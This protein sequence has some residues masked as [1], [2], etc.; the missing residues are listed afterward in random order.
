M[1]HHSRPPP[2]TSEAPET[3]LA[4]AVANEPVIFA[5][6][7]TLQA[8]SRSLCA[9]P[10]RKRLLQDLSPATS[11]TSR[12]RKKAESTDQTGS[13]LR[14]QPARCD[15]VEPEDPPAK[16]QVASL[17][18]QL[19]KGTA[20]AA[21][22]LLQRRRSQSRHLLNTAVHQRHFSKVMQIQCREHPRRKMP[23]RSAQVRP[24][25]TTQ[26]TSQ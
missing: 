1:K 9:R 14:S 6:Q 10:L 5:H 20:S 18:P 15:A 13:C 22:A 11:T 17:P 2:K 12:F 4:C 3:S 8:P 26:A 16:S 25:A 23:S 24:K 7:E 19:Q 21:R